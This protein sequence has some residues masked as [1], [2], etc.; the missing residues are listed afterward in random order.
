MVDTL[1]P[2]FPLARDSMSMDI[3]RS[4]GSFDFLRNDQRWRRGRKM[5]L[6]KGYN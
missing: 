2:V 3:V 6:D 4:L 5:E 1:L